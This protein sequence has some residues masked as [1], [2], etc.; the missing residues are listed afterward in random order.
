MLLTI[1]K[2]VNQKQ[3][4]FQELMLSRKMKILTCFCSD[5]ESLNVDQLNYIL[6]QNIVTLLFQSLNLPRERDSQT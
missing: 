6:I 1:P 2:S 4:H 5:C 3:Y